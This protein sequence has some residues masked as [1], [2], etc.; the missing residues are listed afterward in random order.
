M[1]LKT[2]GIVFRA[3]KYS[4]TSLIVDI[5]TEARGLRKY[6]VSGVRKAKSSVSAGLFQVMSLVEIVAY[7]REG[8]DLNRLKEI[9]PAYIFTGIPFD[10]RKGAV[11]LFMA[12]VARKTI[13]ESEENPSLFD[14]FFRSFQH[15]DQTDQPVVNLHLHFMLELSTFLGFTPGGDHTEETP[16]FDLQEGVFV[17][18][19]GSHPYFLEESLAVYLYQL[20]ESSME[21]SHG[22][23]IGR[24]ERRKL[25]LNLLDY[26]RL[27]LEGFPEINAHLI[28]Q[29]VF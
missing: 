3:I 1:L 9:R 8:K 26:Y 14:F 19:T 18:E 23:K 21:S 13:R 5:Y 15:L 12:E 24:E 28:L 4:E 22:V 7:E 11:G 29:E 20:L 17:G 25:L 27:H 10:L 2:R 16:Y 6:I